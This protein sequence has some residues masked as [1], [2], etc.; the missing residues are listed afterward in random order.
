MLFDLIDNQKLFYSFHFSNIMIAFILNLKFY[1]F[2]QNCD[3]MIPST[4]TFLVVSNSNT[5]VLS[6]DMLTEKNSVPCW[7]H[8]LWTTNISGAT[9]IWE[10]YDA[11][12]VG[13]YQNITF[14]NQIGIPGVPIASTLRIACD[15]YCSVTIN[16]KNPGCQG[17]SY[18]VGSERNCSLLPFL[19]PGINTVLFSVWNSIGD[20]GLLYLIETITIL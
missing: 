14:K 9:W 5:L 17:A 8:P 1:A 16:G 6:P 20:A 11:K 18:G 2:A 7:V 19:V 4:F 3:S 13:K 15:D 10:I 12:T